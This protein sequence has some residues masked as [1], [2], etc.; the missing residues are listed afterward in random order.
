M[1]K[2]DCIS[3]TYSPPILPNIRQIIN[4]RWHILNINNTFGNVFKA[5]PVMAFPK[6]T[7]LR[8]IIGTNTISHNQNPLKVTQNVTKRECI[9]CNTSRLLSCQQIIS[10]TKFE[11][12]QT[13]EKFDI[14]HKISC[15][16]NYVIY[17]IQYIGKSEPLF[18]IIL[19]KHRKNIKNL[20]A[21]EACKHFNNCNHV[22]HKY[23]KLMLI[24]QLNTG[25][26]T[27]Q[28]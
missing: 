15:K 7:S 16:S 25:S 18:C 28:V 2:P 5:T 22:F 19:N 21:I 1:E 26:K 13:K 14:Y 23:G 11:S 12:I 20:H 6:N 24:E 27:T 9:S 8:Q 10:T 4:K 3:G 17:L